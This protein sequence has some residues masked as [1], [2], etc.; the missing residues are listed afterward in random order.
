M[1]EP[2]TSYGTYLLALIFVLGLF[3]VC[4][5]LVRRYVQREP[6]H[7]RGGAKRFSVVDS[8]ILDHRHRVV[9]LQNGSREHTILLGP[10]QATVLDSHE[11]EIMPEAP[12]A[13]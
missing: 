4:A 5:M 9:L 12:D 11:R 10:E 7:K 1:T 2:V 6:W 3:G 13:T 8:L